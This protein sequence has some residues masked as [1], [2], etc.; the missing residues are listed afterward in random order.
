MNSIDSSQKKTLIGGRGTKELNSKKTS[1]SRKALKETI[2]LRTLQIGIVAALLAAWEWGVRAGTISSFL[3]ASPSMIADVL[4]GRIRD[5]SLFT[6]IAV[7]GMETLIG[8]VI[9][10]I[11]GSFIGLAFWYSRFV[12]KLSAPFIA[13]LGSIPILALAPLI[14]IW[15]GT[16]LVSKIAIV[17]FSCIIV[18]LVSSYEGAQQVDKDLMNLMRSF[19]ATKNQIFRKI[20]VPSSMTWVLSGLKM[21]VGFALVGAIVGEY[22]SSNQG[23]GH[24]ILIGSSNFG[25]DIVL[26]GLFTVMIIVFVLNLIVGWLEK[27]LMVWKKN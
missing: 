16:G 20:V 14:I 4:I 17:V 8:F 27:A 1:A 3:F 21:N 15:F 23:I 19:G 5:G 12:A 26:A 11:A 9:G 13:A 18:S 10:S 2:L 22:I 24:M 6:D 25:I 7:T